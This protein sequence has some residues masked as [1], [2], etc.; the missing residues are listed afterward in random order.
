M[1]SRPTLLSSLR[2]SLIGAWLACAYGIAVL[3]AG[4]APSTA[5]AGPAELAQALLCSGQ[6]VPGSDAPAEPEHCKGCIVTWL[7]TVPPSGLRFAPVR[8]PIVLAQTRPVAAPPGSAAPF[9]LQ[10]S[11]GPPTG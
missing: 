10:P 3:A 9:G 11:R 4:L 7:A 8:A 2:R 1:T 6:T 5:L